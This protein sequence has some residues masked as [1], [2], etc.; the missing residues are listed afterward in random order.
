MT[1]NGRIIRQQALQLLC[2]FDAGNES[3]TCITTEPF[4]ED[5]GITSEPL[6]EALK[7]A[8]TVWSNKSIA[9]SQ[10]EP[11]T[12]EWPIHRQPL[13]DR[14]ILRLA[15]HEMLS[16]M[17][18]PIVAI[19]EAIELARMFSTEKSSSF[20]NGVLDKLFQNL[21]STGNEES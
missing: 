1:Q 2:Q 18:P 6:D 5:T 19:D 20:V 14:N 11:L 4:D 13:V 15:R 7:L 3:V 16:G 12:P 8:T 10:I 21:N 17:T 9:D